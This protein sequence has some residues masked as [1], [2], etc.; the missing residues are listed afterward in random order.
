MFMLAW[1]CRDGKKSGRHGVEKVA[2]MAPN[3]VGEGWRIE[4]V[5]VGGVSYC[6][7]SLPR[8]TTTL[9]TARAQ[10]QKHRARQGHSLRRNSTV[11]GSSQR[12]SVDV[13]SGADTTGAPARRCDSR[14]LPPCACPARVKVYATNSSRERERGREGAGRGR[15]S[16]NCCV[17]SYGSGDARSANAAPEGKNKTSTTKKIRRGLVRTRWFLGRNRTRHYHNNSNSLTRERR[18]K[19]PHRWRRRN[20]QQQQE[21]LTSEGSAGG[22][23]TGRAGLGSAASG[24]DSPCTSSLASRGRPSS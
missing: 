5:G 16:D 24:S 11:P 2:L 12:S 6:R 3:G 1:S 20:Q 18:Q 21:R 23:G 13:W 22:G 14:S 4:D 8:R 7:Y 15:V 10:S 17:C 19:R 9:H